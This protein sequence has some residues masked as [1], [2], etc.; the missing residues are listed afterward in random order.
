MEKCKIER[1]QGGTSLPAPLGTFPIYS[2]LVRV[3]RQE[4]FLIERYQD[5][6]ITLSDPEQRLVRKFRPRS[7]P[8]FSHLMTRPEIFVWPTPAMDYEQERVTCPLVI[9]TCDGETFPQSFN[10]HMCWAITAA[11]PKCHWIIRETSHSKLVSKEWSELG[12]GKLISTSKLFDEFAGD[13]E[14]L[15]RLSRAGIG[16]FNPN[17]SSFQFV[18]KRDI[19]E[20]LASWYEQ[21]RTLQSNLERFAIQL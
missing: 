8:K 7:Q 6:S 2:K 5:G 16:I 19:S 17:P 10:T 14:T 20:V 9:R 11:Y 18:A 15:H 13:N 1:G 12:F 3:L 4:G 21:F